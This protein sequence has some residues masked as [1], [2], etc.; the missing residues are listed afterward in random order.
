MSLEF[1]ARFK[2]LEARIAALENAVKAL[3]NE[4]GRRTVEGGDSAA[5]EAKPRM[6]VG[7][8]RTR[9]SEVT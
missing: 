6:A 2:H 9:K 8:P 3:E 5:G 4:N 7:R 1:L